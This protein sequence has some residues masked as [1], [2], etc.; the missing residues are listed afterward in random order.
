ME[1]NPVTE[2]DCPNIYVG[3]ATAMNDISIPAGAF[4]QMVICLEQL[5]HG[6][7]GQTTSIDIIEGREDKRIKITRRMPWKE[8][9]YGFKVEYQGRNVFIDIM[10]EEDEEE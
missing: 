8:G 10:K 1:N 3:A 4:V 5:K 7:N 9:N 2:N 6:F